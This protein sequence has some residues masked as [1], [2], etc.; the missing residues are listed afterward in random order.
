[1]VLETGG[2]SS[3]LDAPNQRG[4]LSRRR[5]L[6]PDGRVSF[7]AALPPC[8]PFT[9]STKKAVEERDAFQRARSAI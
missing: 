1:M 9:T 4:L 3:W 6:G 5:P 7:Y 8:L 2:R